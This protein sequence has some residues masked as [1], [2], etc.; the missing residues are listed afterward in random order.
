VRSE[1]E[2]REEMKDI[3]SGKEKEH[4][5]KVGRFRLLVLSIRILTF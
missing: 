3:I 4:N 5:L 1:R 2:N